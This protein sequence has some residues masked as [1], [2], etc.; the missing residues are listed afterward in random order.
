[1]SLVPA[2]IKC[3]R[4]A[5]YDNTNLV[6]NKF[7]TR[8]QWLMRIPSVYV[9]VSMYV[10][11]GSRYCI[12]HFCAYMINFYANKESCTYPITDSLHQYTQV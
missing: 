1:M 7:G 5:A 10:L 8:F 9:S 6:R 12:I 11:S 4:A 3:Y 2:K